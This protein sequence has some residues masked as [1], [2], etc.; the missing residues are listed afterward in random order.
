MV[1]TFILHLIFTYMLTYGAFMGRALGLEPS[2]L[3][4]GPAGSA[5]WAPDSAHWA[6]SPV[7]GSKPSTFPSNHHAFNES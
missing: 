1:F 4:S 6:P 2:A 5:Y 3:C 7:L